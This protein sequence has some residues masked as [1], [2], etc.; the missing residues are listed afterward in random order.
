[1][2]SKILVLVEHR[3]GKIKSSSWEALGLGQKL[4]ADMG[5]EAKAV[6]LGFQVEALAQQVSERAGVEVLLLDSEGAEAYAPE[7][8]CEALARIAEQESP[9]LILMGHTYQ[10]MDFAPR[11]AARLDRALISN[12][13][14]CYLREDQPVFVRPVYGGKLN[15]EVGLNGSPPCL[16]SVQQ[17]AFSPPQSQMPFPARVHRLEIPLPAGMFQRE[18]LEVIQESCGKVDLSQAEIVVA[19][20]RG[21]ASKEKFQIILDL[22][23]VL[24][25]GVGASRPVTDGDWLPKEHQ[26]GSSG[27]T[28][29]PKLYIACGISGAIQHLV[30]MSNSGC[31]VAINKDPNAPIFRVADFGIVGDVFKV[32]PALTNLV[33]ELRK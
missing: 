11:L 13:S 16:V 10:A 14:D 4:A 5:K 31:I 23:Q 12:C 17:G 15:A 20:G 1:M 18:V 19:G 6:V 27:Q 7:G 28:V 22:A 9:C 25:A 2:A 30:G 21:L 29:S 26:I 8:Y 3:N 32:V 24:G 33:R